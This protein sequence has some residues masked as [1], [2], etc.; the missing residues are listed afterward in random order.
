MKND[1][2]HQRLVSS[3]RHGPSRLSVLQLAVELFTARDGA[4]YWLRI[5]IFAYPTCI[6]RPRCG[7]LRR[8][9]AITFGT[10]NEQRVVIS[11]SEKFLSWK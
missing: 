4:R 6:R 1:A 8:N 5:A 2:A 3:T 10:E 11:R 9:I 7:G